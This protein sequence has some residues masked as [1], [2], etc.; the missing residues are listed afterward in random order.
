MSYHK[1]LT[2]HCKL[3]HAF[4][5]IEKTFSMAEEQIEDVFYDGR[6]RINKERIGKRYA[7]V[8]YFFKTPIVLDFTL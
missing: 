7:K 8:R 2:V 6:I 5:V 4:D 3:L 1:D